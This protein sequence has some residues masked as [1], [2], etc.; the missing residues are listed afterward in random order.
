MILYAETYVGLSS[1]CGN[2]EDSVLKVVHTYK[3]L[4]GH[5]PSTVTSISNL[6]FRYSRKHSILIMLL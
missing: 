5:K 3:T 6:G 4:V 1:C 2:D